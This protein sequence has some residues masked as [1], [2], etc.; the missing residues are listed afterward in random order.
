MNKILL[1][2]VC[3]L[4]AFV[5]VFAT[6]YYVAPNGN[7]TINNGTSLFTPFLTIQKAS[8]VAVPGDVVF[9]RAGVYREMVDLKAD[10]VTYQ[11]YN[12]EAVT[13]N[14]T[15]LMQSWTVT[16]GTTY[17][18]TM[19][20]NV[21]AAWGSN[22]LFADG[23]MMELARWPN[24]TSTDI[25]APTN[26][27]ADNVTASGN[28]FTII[29]ADFN[30]PSS[31]WVG[32]KIWVNLARIG[33]DGQGWTGTVTATSAGSITV[34][35]VEPPRLGDEPWS[36]GSN[37][38]F[39]LFDPTATG[40][41]NS[42]GVDALLS[43]GEW[44]KNGSILYVKTPNESIPSATGTGAN[45]I[46]AKRRHFAF[47]SSVTRANY[48]IKNFNLFGCSITTDKDA[49]TNRII[50]EAAHD[51]IID[52][53]V[54]KYPSHQ[55]DMTGNWQDQHYNWSGIVISG[56]N[57][58]IRNCN[59]QLTAT[60]ALSV[61]GFGNKVLNNTIYNTNYMC[62]NAGAL[63]TGFVCFDVEIANNVL[64]NTTMMAINFRY[65]QNSNINV[66]DVCR[67]HHN[68]VYDFMRR[69]GDSG[70]ID[71]FGQDG[72]WIRIDHNLIYTTKPVIGTMVHGIYLDYGGGTTGD[73]G[74][75]TLD[76]N[77]VVDLPAPILLNNLQDVNIYNNVLL[78][79]TNNF[80]IEGSSQGV[81]TNI[82]NNITSKPFNTTSTNLILASISNNVT[83]AMGAK[84]NTYFANATGNDYRLISTATA[85]INQGVSVGTYDE[86]V[87]GVPDIG[88][89]EYA[90][91]ADAVA[92]TQPGT[93][94]GNSITAFTFN[95][96]W[97]ASTDAA[98]VAYY[99]VYNNGQYFGS[100]TTNNY[101]FAGLV[102]N[103]S[104][105][106]TIRAKDAAGNI[107][108]MS[109]IGT[110]ATLSATNIALSGAT[111]YRW[112]GNSVAKSNAN[113][114]AEPAVNDGNLTTTFSL[115]GGPDDGGW[116]FEAAGVIF[117]NLQNNVSSLNFIQ[118]DIINGNTAFTNWLSMQY[119]KDGTNWIESQWAVSPFYP[120]GN[121][122]STGKTYVFSGPTISGVKGIRVSGIVF[123]ND[124]SWQ[125]TLK[126]VR[127]YN[128]T[129]ADAIAPTVPTSLNATNITTSSFTFNWAASTD[130]A[131][132]TGYEVFRNGISIGT[133]TGLNI[134]ITGLTAA[135]SYSMTVR[136]FDAA[137][138]YSAQS[139]PALNVTTIAAS[140]TGT[141]YYWLNMTTATSNNTRVTSPTINDNNIV[142][143]VMLPDNNN[144]NTWQGA[145]IVW[146]TSKSNI[147][148]VEY[149][150]GTELSNGA[151]NG[152]FTAN[153]ALQFTTNGSTWRNVTGWSISPAY[154]YNNSSNNQMYTFTGAALPACRGVRIVGQV[155]TNNFSWAVHI[156]E[157]K[158]FNSGN[159]LQRAMPAATDANLYTTVN[160]FPNP[161]SNTL[162]IITGAGNAAVTI[163]S[164]DGRV[165]K[166]FT[167]TGSINTI[168]VSKWSKGIYVVNMKIKNKLIIR[169][170]EVN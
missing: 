79:N 123:T 106:I 97:A 28:N 38:E 51:I 147:T 85:A 104:Y 118:G 23:N 165:V 156:R 48:T 155:Y 10:G 16:S 100:T 140:S 39:F 139:S 49:T 46:E 12:G 50:V 101:A 82:K 167:S 145:G 132:V 168:D 111:G 89:F 130:A 163:F 116:K 27:V 31:R 86:N 146:P 153:I 135:T 159:V 117:N 125:A 40:V 15:D 128:N 109:N 47:W 136:A 108:P 26:A 43:N 35:F 110:V 102:P 158:I 161:A 71:M 91:S 80:S 42:G 126:E 63:N 113:R 56:R 92:P 134:S 13:I 60:A 81:N 124:S 5:N 170:I 94:A 24:Q 37:T 131:V 84:A 30:E 114:F 115:T 78:S 29:D 151:G 1:S 21:D 8:D 19:G 154:P 25:V 107:S 143:E 166:Q 73:Q 66:R 54:A 105:S 148:K 103:T 2:F 69:S 129:P 127:A 41:N 67:I 34:A 122:A 6:N 45:V 157:V 141:G 138:N 93:P 121:T 83:D 62:S 64:Y 96:A 61:S 160:I 32:A 137:G 17:Q 150:N 33:Y 44:W 3:F 11:P 164:S 53:I 119:S 4:V 58:I 133:V 22:Q 36:V 152:Y 98:G 65:A 9:V 70:G 72:K 14:G 74:H 7:N 55:T 142:D 68:T 95:V 87:V 120:Y 169:R 59:I 162:H 18:T 149:Y 90:A 88:A 144:A 99:E 20:W 75:Y 112:Y 57:N 76:H 52:G 77:V